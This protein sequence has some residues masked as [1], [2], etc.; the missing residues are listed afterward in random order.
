MRLLGR[1][2]SEEKGKGTEI[3]ESKIEIKKWGLG[4]IQRYRELYTP[5]DQGGGGF[6][7]D[8]G[9]RGR[10]GVKQ[11]PLIKAKAAA[12]SNEQKQKIENNNMKQLVAPKPPHKILNE[13]MGG[14]MKFEYAENPPLPPGVE[15]VHTRIS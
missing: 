8:R 9:G 13:M 11:S 6:R 12:L 5:L 14:P 15:Q 7:G 1:T 2:S 10:G 3:S 4:R